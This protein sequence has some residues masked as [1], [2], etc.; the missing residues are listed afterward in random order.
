MASPRGPCPPRLRLRRVVVNWLRMVAA[1]VPQL[2]DQNWGDP[3]GHIYSLWFQD[4]EH[5]EF[6]LIL[7]RN[8]NKLG[9]LEIDRK[10][11]KLGFN[12]R[13]YRV[14]TQVWIRF[15][16][17]SGQTHCYRV[18]LP[19]LDG[20]APGGPPG[21][22]W[23]ASLAARGNGWLRRAGVRLGFGPMLIR[24][25]KLFLIFKP[26]SPICKSF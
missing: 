7:M 5:T 21:P 10:G 8:Q 13:L 22:W 1:R 12:R 24:N 16:L 20:C 2:A 4:V 11:D 14:G 15:N 6:Y 17:L 18:G 19:S 26:F 9:L 25:G 3:E 23:Q